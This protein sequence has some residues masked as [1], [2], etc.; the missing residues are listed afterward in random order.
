MRYDEGDV[1]MKASDLWDSA[2][3]PRLSGDW[4]SA[5]QILATVRS[6]KQL[7]TAPESSGRT[8]SQGTEGNFSSTLVTWWFSHVL[9]WRQSVARV[10]A[11]NLLST[12]LEESSHTNWE[13]P[14]FLLGESL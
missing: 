5:A 6:A 1:K 9:S 7:T 14:F 10:S 3:L 8:R 4:I 13:M 11:L 12:I 2:D